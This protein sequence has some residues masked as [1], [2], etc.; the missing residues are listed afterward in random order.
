MNYKQDETILESF[1]N[2]AVDHLAEIESGL[3]S[4]E[5]YD[6][7]FD[8]ELV[9]AMFREAH[10][11]KAG[12][13]LLGLKQIEELSYRIENILQ[14]FRNRKLNPDEEIISIVLQG[15][16]KTRELMDN[17]RQSDRMDISAQVE[18]FTQ[19]ISRTEE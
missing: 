1:I 3:L 11:L 2:E 15:I 12:A 5:R 19:V 16:D 18:K 8:D 7:R 13:N 10:T 4:L 17:A 14:M 6:Y 9:H